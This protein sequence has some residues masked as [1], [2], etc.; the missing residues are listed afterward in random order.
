MIVLKH[1]GW[2]LSALKMTKIKDSMTLP[3]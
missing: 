1:P 2:I 3:T